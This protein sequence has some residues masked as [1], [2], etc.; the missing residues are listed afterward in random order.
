MIQQS[1]VHKKANTVI[2]IILACH[3]QDYTEYTYYTFCVPGA[4]FREQSSRNSVPGTD[5]T[6]LEKAP[7]SSPASR[8]GGVSIVVGL[9]ILTLRHSDK[10]SSFKYCWLSVKVDNFS[11][12]LS[13]FSMFSTSV[14]TSS[15]LKLSWSA[16]LHISIAIELW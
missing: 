14:W 16:R 11:L 6:N 4:L 9:G 7:P 2:G 10:I 15:F 12:S 5:N 13:T 3:R 8:R 1:F